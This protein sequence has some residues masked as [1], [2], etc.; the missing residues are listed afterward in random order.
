MWA[1]NQS[2]VFTCKDET[3]IF[4]LPSSIDPHVHFS[5]SQNPLSGQRSSPET[6]REQFGLKIGLFFQLRSCSY[7]LYFF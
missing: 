6:D 1:K 7:D 2:H 4:Q 5:E 3:K